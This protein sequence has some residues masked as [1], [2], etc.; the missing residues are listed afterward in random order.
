MSG[1]CVAC[2]HV[3]REGLRFCTDCG[4]AIG[5]ACPGCGAS[6]E[7]G[8]RFCGHCG[9]SLSAAP[10]AGTTC[11]APTVTSRAVGPWANAGER[12]QVTVLFADVAR[13]MDLAQLLDAD[14]LTEVMQGLFALCQRAVEEF[15]GIV[16]K[17][18]GDGVMALFG[19]PVAQEDH[20]RRGCHAALRLVQEAA[21]Y[22]VTLR[23]RGVE[24][25]VRV[26][27]NSGEVV[28][29]SVGEAFTAVG[30]TVG[31]AQRMESAATPGSVCMSEYTAALVGREFR[32]RD[33]G[34]TAV[35]GSSVPV[36][37]FALDG[38]VGG[39]S[40]AAR[41]RSGSARLVGRDDEVAA[42]EAALVGAE[43]GSA[44][45][46]GLVGE[47]GAGKS[48]LCEELARRAG[49]LGVRV[50]R[51]A[52]VSHAQAVPLLPI[53]GLFQDYFDVEEGD[54]PAE[55]RARVAERFLALD[56]GLEPDLGLIFDF[57]EVP[58]PDRPAP[59]LGP[60]ARRRRIL[61]VLRRVTSR[62][63]EQQTLLMIFEDLHW[64]DPHSVTFLQE[65]LPSFPGTRTLVVTNF[66]PE[67]R[68]PWAASS[69]YRQ[70]P[71][72]PLAGP[73]VLAL[74]DELLGSDPSLLELTTQLRSRTGG[75]PFFAEEIV[76]GLATDGTLAGV[77][78]SY[79][80]TRPASDVRLP[81]TVQAVLAERIDR[82][83]LQDKSVLQAASVIGR[84]FTAT[85]LGPVAG[86]E[87]GAL[88]ESLRSLCTRELLQEN[89]S[90]GEYRFWH[91]LTQEV[92]YAGLLGASRRRLHQG[93][94]A[95]LIALG[96]DR[97]D[98]LAPLIATHFEAAE[99]HLE[100]GRWQF[101]AGSRAS[102]GDFAELRRRLQSSIDHLAQVTGDSREALTLGVRARTV[103][104]RFGAS[105]GMDTVEADQLSAEGRSIAE[106]LG[107]PGLLA[108]VSFADGVARCY[109]GD[110]DGALASFEQANQ[111]A[112]Q[113]GGADLRA[114]VAGLK[115][116]AS[117][118]AG[119]L[120]EGLR[121]AETVLAVSGG[122]PSIGVTEAGY[123]C[124]DWVNML[125]AHLCVA[126]GRLEQARRSAELALAGYEQRP[127][128][129]WHTWT[130]SAFTHL[131]D[132]T[133][134]PAD[135]Q[136]AERAAAEALRL[137]GD[138]GN[139]AAATVIA[140]QAAGAAALLGERPR[141]AAGSLSEALAEARKDR[142]GLMYEAS[143]LAYLA[144]AQLAMAEGESARG[145][146]DEAVAVARRQRATVMEC[147]AQLVR[148][149]V[150]RQ[151]ARGDRDLAEALTAVA[152]G[153][154]LAAASGADTYAAFLA[155][156]R[157]RLDGGDLGKVAVGYEAIGATGHARRV[158]EELAA[159]P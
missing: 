20:A 13:S 65:W 135:V 40:R 144:R 70:I 34:P 32:L 159:T 82:L 43:A 26:G 85:V 87:P 60:E 121:S 116:W 61:E 120:R 108:R 38:A 153:E 158:R 129:A 44:Q 122:D 104:L 117:I 123:S 7:P 5:V 55:V 99:D 91:P 23:Q 97:H 155:E 132:A 101:R 134:E 147:Q 50:R 93:V 88:G 17:F 94:A 22:G 126:A 133:G 148:A 30:H 63:S 98:E 111:Q 152:A 58:D 118:F 8:G 14:E 141:Q 37:V 110:P 114:F 49:E 10:P 151:T 137:A 73:A 139:S 71:L 127:M 119:P 41:R 69:Y 29:G 11:P 46:I 78:G 68:A 52:G 47:A 72:A 154:S 67:F 12:K 18:T 79:R 77:G 56:P 57:L 143:A 100:A 51:C 102:R 54:A 109:R 66:R 83:G 131:A 90:D 138:S 45:V 84:T 96:P 103:L 19:A 124:Y 16:D 136:R 15:G 149:R 115:A 3:N 28:A 95:G 142:T 130:M 42:L 86:L 92:A 156:E 25:A 157:A 62:R 35:K 2:G 128:A 89:G 146:A 150:L 74:L 59:K 106:R 39:S 53:L 75:N 21:A 4:A 31:L 145:S 105:A 107:D 140:M 36:R 125:Q 81:P 27:L 1:L 33:L 64:F 112:D 6:A 113:D 9:T 80:L 48:R 24:L 76:R